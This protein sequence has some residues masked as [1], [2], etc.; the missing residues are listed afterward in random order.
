MKMYVRAGVD[1]TLIIFQWKPNHS[2][3]SR[4]AH[5]IVLSSQ[6]NFFLL[7]TT[8]SYYLGLDYCRESKIKIFFAF[9]NPVQALQSFT[10]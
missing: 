7:G 9:F 4:V 6:T 1:Y 10:K 2:M 3:Y 5:F 8:F